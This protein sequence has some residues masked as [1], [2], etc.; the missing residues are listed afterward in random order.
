MLS[1]WVYDSKLCVILGLLIST[2]V[3]L[4][5]GPQLH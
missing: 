3:R 5:A 4:E 1:T 2:V